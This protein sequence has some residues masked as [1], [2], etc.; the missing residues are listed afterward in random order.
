MTHGPMI[1]TRREFGKL[2]AA[3]PLAAG[4]AQQQRPLYA[5][6]G[7]GIGLETFSFHDLPPSG[8]PRL[9]PTIIRNMRE[10]GRAHV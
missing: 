9:I 8:D 1:L 10:I 5:I 4:V 7:V 2:I 6:N 3:A